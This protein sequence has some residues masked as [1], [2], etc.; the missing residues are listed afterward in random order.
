MVRRGLEMGARME[1]GAVTCYGEGC[2]GSGTAS[3]A[4]VWTADEI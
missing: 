4:R 2:V 1:W 3:R